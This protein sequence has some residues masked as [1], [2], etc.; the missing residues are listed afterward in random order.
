MRRIG[1]KKLQRRDWE[2]NK[3]ERLG[4]SCVSSKRQK[5]FEKTKQI[6]IQKMGRHQ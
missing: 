3:K 4:E 6:K 1:S 2:G 5:L